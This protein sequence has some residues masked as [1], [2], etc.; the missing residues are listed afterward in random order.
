MA[1]V[2][3]DA[4]SASA[5]KWPGCAK[6]GSHTIDSNRQARV[7]SVRNRDGGRDLY[8]CL[9]ADGRPQLLAHGFDDGY[10]ASNSYSRVRLSGRFVTWQETTT[11]ASCK[12]DCPPGYDGTTSA[13]YTRDLKRRTTVQLSGPAA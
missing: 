1:A 10:T 6:R 9:R 8:G 11:D 4:A 12:A 7:Y 2:P 13:R 5:K 3:A